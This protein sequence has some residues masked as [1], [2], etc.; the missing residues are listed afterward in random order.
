MLTKVNSKTEI[1]LSK[2]AIDSG[3]N[4]SRLTYY[5]SLGLISPIRE[6]GN[7]RGIY[8]RTKTR[9][10][11]VDIARMQAKGFNLSQI[12]EH[13]DA[14]DKAQGEGGAP[15]KQVSHAKA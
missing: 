1:T 15:R 7:N 14:A 10:R 6:D 4:K 2:L 5:A 3:V 9:L 13:F 11:I 12:K 8:D